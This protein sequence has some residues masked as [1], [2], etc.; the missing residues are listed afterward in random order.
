LVTKL[1]DNWK[2]S[3][4]VAK[5]QGNQKDKMDGGAIA[6]I[7]IAVLVGGPL[8]VFLI[9]LALRR[10]MQ[11]P[12]TGS[13]NPKRLDDKVIVITGCNT[14]I[15]KVT[16][17][18]LSKR[19]ARIIM[20]CRN[21]E[22]AEAAAQ[23]IRKDTGNPVEV[24]ELDLASL[25]S[26][27]N[28]ATK[29]LDQEDQIDMLINNAGVMLCPEMR[30]KEGFEMQIGTNHLGHFLLTELLLPKLKKSAASGFNARILVLSSLAHE[31]GVIRWDDLNFNNKGSYSP[32][33]AYCQSKLANVMHAAALAPRLENT[34]ITVYSLH[35][36]VINTELTRH[37][38]ES[39]PIAFRM[40]GP[41][42]QFV[43]K[44][45][46]HGAQTTLYCALEDKLSVQSGKYYSDCAEKM[47]IRPALVEE[48]QEKLWT[49][50]CEL[51]GLN[52]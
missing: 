21:T 22:K 31:S 13:D 16:A 37:A 14:G 17:H 23:E 39:H 45:P 34:G 12:T 49:M 32:V 9:M 48:D 10:F 47:A 1:Q 18:E 36:G 33:K 3:E 8:L 6:G 38:E 4:L 28:C 19:G 11:G 50:S 41:F 24:M 27:R 2:S 42:Y 7:V 40:F 26:V 51:V 52:K 35:P 5:P 25:E 46:F 43:I 15:G 29:L 20:L 44:T 30:T